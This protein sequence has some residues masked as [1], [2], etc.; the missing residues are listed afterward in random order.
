MTDGNITYWVA[1]DSCCDEAWEQAYLDFESP[2]EE[3]SKFVARYRQLGVDR[4]DK[5]LAVAELFCGRGNGLTTL[6]HLGFQNLEGVD[7]SPRLLREFD[8]DVPLYVGDCRDLHW[9]DNHKDVIVV[10]GGLHHLPTLPDDLGKVLQEIRR[11]LNPGGR[12]V[13]VEPW[14]TPFLKVAHAITDRRLVRM[15]YRRGDALARMTERERDTY[16]NWLSRP[17]QI[18][19]LLHSHFEMEQQQIGWGKLMFIG[20][21]AK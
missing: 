8:G 2:A 11:V 3:R 15:F 10:Q 13:L 16:E 9:P 21:V 14:S 7:L 18:L 5:K 6:R 17:Q 20:R 4:W 19:D 12:I 1:D